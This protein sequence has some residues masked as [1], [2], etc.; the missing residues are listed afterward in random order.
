MQTNHTLRKA[1]SLRNL[2]PAAVSVASLR[3]DVQPR[4][5]R[6][7]FLSRESNTMFQI[8]S[9]ST[10]TFLSLPP[11]D[12]RASQQA[13]KRRIATFS[14]IIFILLLNTLTTFSSPIPNT[15]T[16]KNYPLWPIDPQTHEYTT[17]SVLGD[18]YNFHAFSPLPPTPWLHWIPDTLKEWAIEYHAHGAGL[19]QKPI[20]PRYAISVS[21]P[22]HL[23]PFLLGPQT[24]DP[25]STGHITRSNHP[26]DRHPTRT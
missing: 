26:H 14:G 2:L 9:S 6:N 23:K 13:M 24:H 11:K 8:F 20:L 15:T 22:L 18:I 5:S 19:K 12:V 4:Q 25:R 17:V 16:C 7:I 21:Y 1:G 10:F 3:W